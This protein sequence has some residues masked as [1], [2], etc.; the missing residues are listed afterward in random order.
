MTSDWRTS[1][2]AFR[3]RHDGY[4]RAV[5]GAQAAGPAM[6]PRLR[7]RSRRSSTRSAACAADG[8]KATAR[9]RFHSR[10]MEV[11]ADAR[12]AVRERHDGQLQA[13]VA[14]RA[15]DDDGIT[16]SE[17]RR[18]FAHGPLSTLT[19]VPRVRVTQAEASS[20]LGAAQRNR[21]PHPRALPQP[22]R[23]ARVLRHSDADPL[24]GRVL[25]DVSRAPPGSC[26][27]RAPRCSGHTGRARSALAPWHWLPARS[28]RR[29]RAAPPG[30]R[31][32][33]GSRD[34]A[35]TSAG[36]CGRWPPRASR[37]RPR[38]SRDPSH[39]LD[40]GVHAHDT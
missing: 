10:V 8:P 28:G 32:R 35:R 11:C 5:A 27:T 29:A 24:G 9:M 1:G 36:G 19:A 3:A 2:A 7:A 40:A 22:R 34:G 18:G 13:A 39:P 37:D 20:S 17:W 21:E 16:F 15:V 31:S 38:R 4:R 14:A 12:L 30:G 6:T 33:G 23:D 26:G 25:A